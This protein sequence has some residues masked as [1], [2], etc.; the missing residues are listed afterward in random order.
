VPGG[1]GFQTDGSFG[2]LRLNNNWMCPVRGVRGSFHAL[3]ARRGG[4]AAALLLR[5]A[6]AEPEYDGLSNV[7]S[8]TFVGCCPR[9]RFATRIPRSRSTS[10]SRGFTPH[11][12]HDVRESTLPAAVFR[13]RLRNDAST[14][15][16]AAVLFAFENVLGRGGSGKLGLVLGAENEMRGVR[17]R[18]VYD[19]IEGNHQRAAHVG[20]GRGVRFLTTQRWDERSHRRGVTGDYLLL[21]D[22]EPDFDVTV[23]ESW[24]ADDA[25]PAM[26][27][28]FAR[29]GRVRRA[30]SSRR[31]SRGRGRRGAADRAGRGARGRLHARLVDAR[32]RDRPRPRRGRSG[33]RRGVRVGHVYE[34][35][36]AD[37]DAVAAHVLDE[38]E[39]SSRRRAS[40]LASSPTRRFPAWLVRAIVNSIDS[41]LC[42]TIVPATG[43]LHTLEGMDWGWPMGALTGTMDQRLSSHPYGSVFFPDLDLRELDEFR[44]L[45][46]ARGAIPHGNG[47][48]DLA[49]GSTDVPYGWPLVVKDFLPAKEWTDLTMS[50][51]LQVAKH[52]RTTG[53]A[54]VIER[55]WPALVAGMEHL[56][57]LAP[58]GVP[59]GGTTYDIWDFP[60]T[61]VYSATLYLAALATMIAVATRIDPA[62]VPAYRARSARCA[63]RL[64]ALWNPRGYFQTT[65]TQDSIFTSALA[66][67]WA[68]RYAGL[69]PVVDPAR[70]T[71]HLRHAHRVLVEA[72]L[73]AAAERWV[74]M[75]RAEARFDGTP[76]VHRLAA[77]L[78]EGE[79]LT[80]VWQV[81]SYH[82]MEAIYL[83]E[84]EAGLATMR[85]IYDRIWQAGNAWSAGLQGNADSVYM[86]HPVAWAALD[87][88]TGAALDVPGRTLFLSPRTDRCP[89][90]FAPFWARL[91]GAD[92]EVLRT[93]GEP[94]LI[95]RLVERTAAG[96]ERVTRLPPTPLVAGT[97]LRLA[98]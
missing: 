54:D 33:P 94:V 39:R 47:N 64:D 41:T 8:T 32:P 48:A 28:D 90:F 1:F 52:W 74:P 13:F 42:N 98:S 26:L 21:V 38:R 14:P 50:F 25:R 70:A 92:V 58:D 66:G 59:E 89:F 22:P 56:D 35:W 44:R 67:D 85:M 86:T 46:D 43:A 71:S 73:R 88:L 7:S 72:P 84:V 53:R 10:C 30:W 82:A 17:D 61:F 18:V 11:V 77:G 9:S 63:A 27:A 6:G 97:R 51:V 76:V 55:F 40:F 57:R 83:G 23:C 62:R 24:D 29:S 2:E 79:D 75:P 34:R 69:D 37:S 4:E 31:T 60:G 68:A 81:L 80:Y 49:L 45:A 91:D 36:F 93:F 5:R 96:A 15:V 78:P 19:S 65:A 20:G 87:A 3:F 95:D 16:E 12:P